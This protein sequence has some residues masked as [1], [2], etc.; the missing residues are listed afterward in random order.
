MGGDAG[1]QARAAQRETPHTPTHLR[2]PGEPVAHGAR[3][4]RLRAP[5]R[6]VRARRLA[7]SAPARAEGAA[8]RW[9]ARDMLA[10]LAAVEHNS[11]DAPATLVDCGSCDGDG[12]FRGSSSRSPKDC[13]AT[14][15]SSLSIETAGCASRRRTVVRKACVTA[16]V[17][18][19]SAPRGGSSLHTRLEN[20]CAPREALSRGDKLPL[21]CCHSTH[22][23]VAE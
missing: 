23:R 22:G 6:R 21:R 1:G 20:K 7:R 10:T 18:T 4:H 8:H 15:L 14:A 12:E 5:S 16:R 9:P 19:G 11:C 3:P 13:S 17:S 2:Q